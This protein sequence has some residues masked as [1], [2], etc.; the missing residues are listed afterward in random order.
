MRT[1]YYPPTITTK[2]RIMF[3][4]T[5]SLPAE[6]RSIVAEALNATLADGI[7][8]YA[9]IKL[10]H[11]NLK[12]PLFMQLHEMFDELASAVSTHNDDVAERV[13]ILGGVARGSIRRAAKES[14]IGDDAEVTRD[15]DWAR[16]SFE[17][18]QRYLAGARAARVV[19]DAQ[20]DVDTSDLLTGIVQD[21]DKRGWFVSA[22]LDG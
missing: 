7:D 11:W 2:G 19:A 16:A 15:L 10:A 22:T 13:V 5:V 14:R 18:I 20:G 9:Q 3:H 8:L 1:S 17:R 21:L 4:S 12:G 6:K